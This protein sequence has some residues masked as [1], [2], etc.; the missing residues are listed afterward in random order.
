MLKVMGTNLIRIERVL[1]IRDKHY[2][3]KKG[4][5]PSILL[6]QQERST[7]QQSLGGSVKTCPRA[8]GQV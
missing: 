8:L 3:D 5:F 7:G 6:E 2:I 1:A 4:K